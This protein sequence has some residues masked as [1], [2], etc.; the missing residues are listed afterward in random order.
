MKGQEK[1]MKKVCIVCPIGCDLEIKEDNN[2]KDGYGIKGNKCDRGYDYGI[3]EMKNPTRIVTS[4]IKIKNLENV[5]LPVKTTNGIPK[6]K[7]FE[8]MKLINTM[9]I[10]LP[11]NQN[12]V[13]VNNLFET[14]INL[15]A[16]R[17]ML[18]A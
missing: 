15:V 9:E 10:E 8:L 4:T 12:D 6:E 11:I 5:M 7:M 14:D 18:K 17:T 1:V 13:I 16:T 3:T 2:L